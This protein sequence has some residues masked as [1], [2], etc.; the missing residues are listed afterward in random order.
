MDLVDINLEQVK[1]LNLTP[2]LYAYLHC[3]H[4]DIEFPWNLS[5]NQLKDL[6][7]DDW[8]KIGTDGIHLRQKSKDLFHGTTQWNKV[9]EWIN[10]YREI[11]PKGVK[12]GGRP[13][14][15]DKQGCIKKL[16]TYLKKNK[17]VTKEE[18]FDAAKSY[19]FEMK[20]KNYAFMVC[21]DYFI[22]KDG[23]SLL[24]SIIEHRKE[25]EDDFKAED[26]TFHTSI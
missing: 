1:E 6:E 2:T 8:L 17:K 23:V 13:V 20:R 22:S 3:L 19:V 11:F 12:S 9:E 24:S 15:G 4:K 14:R 5:D 10:E 16:T 25:R 18:V 7:K 21:A 26:N